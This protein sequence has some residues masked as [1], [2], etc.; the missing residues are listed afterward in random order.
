M[1]RQLCLFLTITVAI[2][3]STT[4][5]AHQAGPAVQSP[6]TSVVEGA[7][8]DPDGLPVPGVGAQ[9]EGGSLVT[10]LSIVSSADG[11]VRF[12]SVPRPGA[13]VLTTH[14]IGGYLATT[15]PVELGSDET[16]VRIRVKLTLGFTEQVRVSA[17]AIDGRF[18][19]RDESANA[20]TIPGAEIEGQ[21]ARNVVEVLQAVPGFT[22]DLYGGSDTIK[23]KF[24]GVDSQRYY[25]EKPGVAI[26]VDGVPVL[27]RTGRV[28]LDL[29]NID[30][31]RVLKGGAS[32][33]FGDDALSGAV[34]IT[35]KRGVG[36]RGGKVDY[37]A[38]SF[39]Y[40]RVFARAG[41]GNSWATAYVQAV[42]RRSDDYY[43]QSAYGNTAITGSARIFPTKSSDITLG[44]ER[45]ESHAR[46]TRLG[47]RGDAGGGGPARR[48]RARLHA[49]L[50]GR[51]RPGEPH[52]LECL[53]GGDEPDAA[54]VPI[55][56]TTRSSGRPRSDSPAAGLPS[57]ARTPI[58]S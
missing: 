6:S 37:D 42:N 54:R 45:T 18:A 22:P 23:V 30:S 21:H 57:R 8:L 38:G 14:A 35:T 4:I 19:A 47:H 41:F 1:Y 29:D 43:F 25:G 48:S 7:L 2:C 34:I 27:E 51:T 32:Y 17:S 12:T 31:V 16:L 50:P 9:L 40:R 44:F 58:S 28:N 26:I 24:R 3:G 15:T 56:G 10:P 13:Y 33:L 52:L 49:Q 36:D 46:Q 5:S 39:D 53:H 20:T 55:P 11:R